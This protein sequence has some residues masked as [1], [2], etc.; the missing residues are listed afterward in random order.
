MGLL[1]SWRKEGNI[2][3]INGV[4]AANNR[5][6]HDAAKSSRHEDALNRWPLAH[7]IYRTIGTTPPGFS[8]R[9][10]LYGEWGAGKSSVLNFLRE[11]ALK[12]GDVIVHV[13]AW[14]AADTDSF[15]ETLKS[16]MAQEIKDRRIKTS[17]GY[18]F[19]NSF[20]RGS[21]VIVDASDKTGQAAGK[22]D[23]ELS[24]LITAGAVLANAAAKTVEQSLSLSMEDVEYLREM[25][26]EHHVIVFIDDLDRAD[27]K[28]LP[29][30][31]MALREY[32]DWPGF[33]FV[34]AFDKEI[35]NSSLL[36]YSTAFSSS[37]QPFLDKIIDIA[38]ELKTPEQ[39]LATG[40][41]E[42]AM[43]QYCG[44]IPE[45]E[46]SKVAKLFP[47]NP[48][49]AKSIA[50]DL[51]N[52]KY[53]AVR[54]GKGELRWEAII[55]Q[56]LLRRETSECV[57]FVEKNLIGKRKP[58]LGMAFDREKKTEAL[59][60]IEIAMNLSGYTEGSS[61]HNRLFY[62][63]TKLQGLRNFREPEEIAYEM[64]LGI[65][66]PCFTQM[67][68]GSLIE[69]WN[70]TCNDALLSDAIENA[71][72]RAHATP[73]EASIKLLNMVVD[74]YSI[75]VRNIR[76]LKVKTARDS[77]VALSEGVGLFL[78]HFT[79][80]ERIEPIR[81]ASSNSQVCGRILD[82]A[83][84]FS[85]TLNMDEIFLRV[86]ERNMVKNTAM[87][88]SDKVTLFYHCLRH[89]GKDGLPELA[90]SVQYLTADAAVDDVLGLFASANGVYLCHL[91]NDA[92]R[93]LD[94]LRFRYSV[95][96]RPDQKKKLLKFLL[97]EG[98]TEQKS[99]IAK[100]SSDYLRVLIDRMTDFTLFAK[101][102]ADIIEVCWFVIC[103][104]S[105]LSDG[106][107][108]VSAL[109]RRLKGYNVD[110][111]GLPLPS[112]AEH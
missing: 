15:M 32:L 23:G 18:R 80:Q 98:S 94:L 54:H 69:E 86:I 20:R 30:T 83:V 12:N 52:L 96:Y 24:Q 36:E 85:R 56:T 1:S 19:K 10:G 95:L 42:V 11:I 66:A 107:D 71:V 41:A 4:E 2:A 78:L 25:L 16:A 3:S 89:A 8:T 14:R 92:D 40:F 22:F 112:G 84:E 28:I 65:H 17:I 99:V 74:R 58:S 45:E 26:R 49:Q 90:S 100:N 79:K 48:R 29:K 72:D 9:I 106:I 38:F 57:A 97:E 59:N 111:S 76:G 51:G 63:I 31:L 50:R 102:N 67:E 55:L 46:R 60:L 47:E 105:W 101:D 75:S 53:A 91:S 82:V 43:E 77:A 33:A 61:D 44:F 64:E 108:E 70:S 88:C 93:R 13:T 35:I 21:R 109:H 68:I 6:G 39:N 27:P 37:Q 62:I 110:V 73:L 87:H 7:S 81:L 34:L 5:E 103:R 104:E